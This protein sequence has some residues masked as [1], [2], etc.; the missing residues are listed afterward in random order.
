MGAH[1]PGCWQQWVR[2]GEQI[3]VSGLH[4]DG[5]KQLRVPCVL[6]RRQNLRASPVRVCVRACVCVRVT[7]CVCV[8]A[9]ARVCACACVVVRAHVRACVVG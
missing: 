2:A 7:V 4:F 6:V 1:V 8:R 9:R 3:V 5:A